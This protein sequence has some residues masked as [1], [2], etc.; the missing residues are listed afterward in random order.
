M[1]EFLT[2]SS[3]NAKVFSDVDSTNLALHIIENPNLLSH[4]K[5]AVKKSDLEGEKVAL[6]VDLGRIVGVTS[7]V[8][9]HDGDEIVYAKRLDRDSYSKF[10]KNR[11]LV[12]TSWVVA[13]LFKEEYGYLVWSGWCGRLLPQEPDGKGGSRTAKE[14]EASHALVYDPKIIQMDTLKSSKPD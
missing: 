8:E 5:E 10:V 13:I 9:I 6:E 4:I 1:V 7:M 12:P 2:N 14:F 11:D 3:N